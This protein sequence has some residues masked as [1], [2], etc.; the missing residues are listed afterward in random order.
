MFCVNDEIVLTPISQS[1]Y[2][3]APSIA[4]ENEKLG[5]SAGRESLAIHEIPVQSGYGTGIGVLQA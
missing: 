2:Y 1:A 5:K 3:F 4:V